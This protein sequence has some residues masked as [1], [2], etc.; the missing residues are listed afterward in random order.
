MD[1]DYHKEHLLLVYENAYNLYHFQHQTATQKITIRFN[2]DTNNKK[3]IIFNL[4]PLT[5]AT[6]AYCERI[7]RNVDAKVYTANFILSSFDLSFC[8]TIFDGQHLFYRPQTLQ[9]NGWI[10]SDKTYSI[11]RPQIIDGQYKL[12]K[13]TSELIVEQRQLRK[14][15]YISRGFVIYDNY[16]D[17]P[18]THKLILP[19]III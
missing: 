4:I 8:Q 6:D 10:I 3:N 17:C 7:D 13:I 15:K 12:K 1:V 11:N 16:D 2:D 18:S 19:S 9:R 14:E 5:S